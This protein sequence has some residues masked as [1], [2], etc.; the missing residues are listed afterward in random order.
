MFL[1]KGFV[2]QPGRNL[3]AGFTLI[4]L[5]VVVLIIGILAAVAVPQY[6]KAVLK[7]RF[8]ALMPVVDGLAQAQELFYISNDR[9]ADEFE[10]LGVTPAGCS[11]A[12]GAGTRIC[13]GEICYE[14]YGQ[15]VFAQHK[16]FALEYLRALRYN[17]NGEKRY[18]IVSLS[19]AAAEEKSRAVCK[20]LGKFER[21]NDSYEWWAL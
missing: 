18:C 6:E 7:S 20:S 15:G 2:R 17:P 12:S 3:R 5:L 10:E 19:S 4:E 11:S 21:K 1:F 9:Y 16:K 14:I 13:C 8:T